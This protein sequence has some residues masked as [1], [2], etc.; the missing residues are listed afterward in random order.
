MA[1][2]DPRAANRRDPRDFRG[3]WILVALVVGWALGAFD[4]WRIFG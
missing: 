3:Y 2:N 1:M 4:F